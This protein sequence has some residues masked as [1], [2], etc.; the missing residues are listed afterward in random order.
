[1]GFSNAL[2]KRSLLSVSSVDLL[3][4]SQ[5]IFFFAIWLSCVCV[6]FLFLFWCALPMSVFYRVHVYKKND[7]KWGLE[8]H[9]KLYALFTNLLNS[10][11]ILPWPEY[12]ALNF[13]TSLASLYYVR[14]RIQKIDR[15][16]Q[17]TKANYLLFTCELFFERSTFTVCDQFLLIWCSVHIW[18][19]FWQAFV[20]TVER[21]WM[22]TKWLCL[23]SRLNV[24]RFLSRNWAKEEI[25]Q[26][27]W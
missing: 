20:I 18:S 13:V 3:L 2:Y 11:P 9:P 17:I 10:H 22:S 8:S 12:K 15:N 24:M 23:K 6:F 14:C 16:R 1:M 21:P 4:S 26:R 19:L 27:F 25:F 5:C 7:W